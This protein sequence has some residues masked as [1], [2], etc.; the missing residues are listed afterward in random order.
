MSDKTSSDAV[1]AWNMM[2]PKE[3]AAFD[4]LNVVVE[5]SKQPANK[6]PLFMSNWI[7]RFGMRNIMFRRNQ[8][9]EMWIAVVDCNAPLGYAH[10][11]IKALINQPIYVKHKNSYDEIKRICTSEIKSMDS[12]LFDFEGEP[13]KD[14]IMINWIG[15]NRLIMRSSNEGAEAF[16]DWINEHVIPSLIL[17]GHYAVSEHINEL[18]SKI[19]ALSLEKTAAEYATSLVDD[20]V[21]EKQTH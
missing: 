5:A 21:Q 1:L 10:N 6:K 2:L 16:A 8:K 20:E 3:R 14:T 13:R 17:D 4:M 7:N 19:A 18:E 9:I 11:A 12:I 15:F